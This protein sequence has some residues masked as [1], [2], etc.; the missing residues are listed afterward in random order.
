MARR[1]N[2]L[3]TRASS[4]P[5]AGPATWTMPAREARVL[6]ATFGELGHDVPAL[7]SAAELTGRNFED[8]DARLNCEAY[9]A[10]IT[11]AQ[12]QRFT[13]NL[14]LEV[15][16]RTPLGA[17]PLLDYL[18]ITSDSVGSGI[19]QL[20]RYFRIQ[21]IPI[22]FDIRDDEDPVEV[23]LSAPAQFGVENLISL[24]TF[25]LRHE[26]EGRFVSSDVMLRHQPDDA[27]AMAAALGCSVR[28]MSA[29][30]G[31]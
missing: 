29:W 11:C 26:T 28:T 12:Q 23:R 20:A 13:P 21:T 9:G 10:L 1:A 25:H 4:R 17:Y 19:R 7:L 16:R 27:A 30:D 14:A 3:T 24:M 31:V 6:L 5:A 2:S 18:V 22:G 15:A 8:P